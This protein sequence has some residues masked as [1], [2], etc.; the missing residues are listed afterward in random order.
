MISDNFEMIKLLEI[1]N[2][3]FDND[4]KCIEEYIRYGA[5]LTEIVQYMLDRG[6]V[7]SWEALKIAVS[8]YN[9]DLVKLLAE[10]KSDFF[11]I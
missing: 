4:A 1:M 3:P 2:Y 8:H 10:K 6:A 7:V 9:L 5:G 11:P